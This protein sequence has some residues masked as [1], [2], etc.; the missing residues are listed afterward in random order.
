MEV[1]K[2][3]VNEALP[4]RRGKILLRA[5]HR[6]DVDIMAHWPYHLDPFFARGTRL[7]ATSS[8][9]DHW[10]QANN[11]E[12][13]STLLAAQ[14]ADGNLIGRV[15]ITRVDPEIREGVMGIRIHPELENQGYGTDL[16]N[17]FLDYW[18]DRQDMLLLSFDAHML[19]ERAISLYKKVG[20]PIV[21]Y[22]YEYQPHF[23]GED[24][25]HP[26]GFA[27]FIDFRIDRALYLEL[28]SQQDDSGRH[29][30]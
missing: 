15:S 11:H 18:F 1:K 23:V 26:S 9:R 20:I 6:R 4:I 10:W 27:K 14:D 2:S 13:Y 30:V 22:Y 12:P 17:A 16:L 5:M 19:N 29:P 28:K 21:G 7:P 3:E 24:R 25:A 8:G